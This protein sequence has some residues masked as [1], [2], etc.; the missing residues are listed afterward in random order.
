MISRHWCVMA[1]RVGRVE[2][3]YESD[4]MHERIKGVKMIYIGC[5]QVRNDVFYALGITYRMLRLSRASYRGL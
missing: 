1:L 4:L 2:E 3:P 5:G